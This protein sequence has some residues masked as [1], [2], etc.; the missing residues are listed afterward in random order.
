MTD[1]EEKTQLVQIARLTLRA[2][3][4]CVTPYSARTSRHDF[5]QAQLIACLVVRAVTKSTY[6]EICE[7]LTL[8]PALRESIGIDK[9]PH[10][11][12]LQKFMAKEQT[13]ETVNAILAQLLKEFRLDTAPIDVAVDSTGLQSGVASLHY[14]TRRWQTGSGKSQKHVKVSIAIVCGALLPIALAVDIGSSA[15]MKQMPVLMQQIEANTQP[16]RLFADAGYDAEWVHERCREVW[17]VESWIPPVI[18]T[19]DGS[20]KTK[21]RSKMRVMPSSY[22]RRWHVESFFSAMKRTTLSSLSSRRVNTLLAEASMKVL[23]Y[24]V[25]R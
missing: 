2:A 15:D 3:S 17:D 23:A 22:G 25:R 9:A 5:T 7:M 21:W 13:P 12:T 6:R 19:A 14:R 10:F 20:I 8:M 4:K 18:H 24:A 11:T 1:A 16:V